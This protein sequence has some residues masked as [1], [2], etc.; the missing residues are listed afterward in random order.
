MLKNECVNQL[1]ADACTGSKTAGADLLKGGWLTYVRNL[2]NRVFFPGAACGVAPGFREFLLWIPYV[3]GRWFPRRPALARRL[4]PVTVMAASLVLSACNT[5]VTVE[6]SLPTPLVRKLPLT[7]GIYY[8][9]AFRDFTHEEKIY[10]QGTW[11]IDMGTQN[12]EFFRGMFTAMFDQSVEI[13]ELDIPSGDEVSAESLSVP[14][15]LDGIIVPEITKYGFLTPQISGLSFFSASIHYRISI[16]DK[17]GN[18]A[19]NWVV[20][21]YGKSPTS[22]FGDGEALKEA[23]ILA[24]RDGGARIA[25]GTVQH[26]AVLK[27]L[28]ANNISME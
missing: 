13:E 19:V 28:S 2:L 26:P 18:L 23:T 24:I 3:G 16:Y 9:P 11:T 1:T 12:L 5:S 15:G 17:A 4:V 7:M 14:E 6:G 25:I 10:E 8:P 21:G 27:W 20:V 22:M